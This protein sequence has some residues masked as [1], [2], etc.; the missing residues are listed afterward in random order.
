VVQWEDHHMSVS[1]L[2]GLG[3]NASWTHSSCDRE[4]DSFDSI[5]FLL[6]CFTNRPILSIEP[7]MSEV[8]T[9]LLIQYFF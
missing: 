3:L 4:G 7:I 8:D 9:Q 2:E 1:P 6:H 5:S